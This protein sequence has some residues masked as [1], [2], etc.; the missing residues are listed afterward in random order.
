MKAI[1]L[2]AGLGKRMMPLTEKK[3]KA[4]VEFNG[5][6]LLWHVLESLKKAG[7]KEALVII[8]YKGQLVEKR[9]GTSFK[10]MK[11]KYV[12]QRIPMGTGH[13]VL[14]AKGEVKGRFLVGSG[15]VIIQPSLWKKLWAKKEQAVI[16]LR[17]EKHPEKFGVAIVKGKKLEKI[18]EKPKG[19]PTGNIVNAGA[20][21]FGQKIFKALERIKMSPRGEFELTD[22]VN[23]LARKGKASYVKYRGKCLDIG[24][25]AE[26][27]KAKKR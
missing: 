17:K 6:P 16:A 25:M 4:L 9:F 3:P 2:A 23:A 1:I 11:L 14:Q 8:G 19:K 27:N 5:K 20:Y 21:C 15:D 24:T 10:G 7:A 22:A 26:L 18:I 13:A 12:E